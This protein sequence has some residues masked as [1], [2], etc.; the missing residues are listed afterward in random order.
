MRRAR[1][2]LRSSKQAC[3]DTDSSRFKCRRIRSFSRAWSSSW[4]STPMDSRLTASSAK[5]WWTTEGRSVDP[6]ASTSRILSGVR[7][8]TRLSRRPSSSETFRSFQ[9]SG[10]KKPLKNFNLQMCRTL[11][12]K[13][14]FVSSRKEGLLSRE[15]TI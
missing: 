6:W 1:G 15:S 8:A 13:R 7:V 10:S 2:R 14:L 3:L 11:S 12:L 9:L 5:R 4:K